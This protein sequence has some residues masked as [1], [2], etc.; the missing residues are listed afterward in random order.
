MDVSYSS[1]KMDVSKIFLHLEVK[2]IE[3]HWQ[4]Q[5]TKSEVR[6]HCDKAFHAHVHCRSIRQRT[7]SKL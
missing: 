5:N 4:K 6:V 3:K 2:E 1:P 7:H